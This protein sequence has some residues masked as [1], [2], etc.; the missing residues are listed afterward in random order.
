MKASQDD[1]LARK[2]RQS[3]AVIVTTTPAQ[4]REMMAREMETTGALVRQLGLHP[5]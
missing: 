2:A 3:G 5:E 1:E 4:L